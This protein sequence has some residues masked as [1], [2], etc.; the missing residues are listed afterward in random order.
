MRL[1]TLARRFQTPSGL[2]V[3]AASRVIFGA[4]LFLAAP[5]SRAPMAIRVAGVVVFVAGLALPWIGHERLRGLFDWW[6]SRGAYAIRAL[7]AVVLASGLVLLYA[8]LP[9]LLRSG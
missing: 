4:A 9:A 6:A 2:Y 8:L 7:G 5:E 1:V 3:A